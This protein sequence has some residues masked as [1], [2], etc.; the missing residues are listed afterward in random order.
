VVVGG[1]PTDV[2]GRAC[3]Q[4]AGELPADVE[5]HIGVGHEKGLRVG[6]DRDELD[7]LEA[8]LDHPVDGVDAATTDADHL[9]DSE[10]V[11]GCSHVLGAL[12]LTESS[13]GRAR[14]CG[15]AP[16]LL[17]ARGRRREPGEGAAREPVSRPSPSG[18]RL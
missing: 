18:R 12:R 5:L 9:D 8:Y 7:A 6:V 2:R 14:S 16:G 11:L 17:V 4:T 13:G 15:H 10:V 3:T 1:L